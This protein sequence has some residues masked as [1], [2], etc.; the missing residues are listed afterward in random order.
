MIA[1]EVSVGDQVVRDL[2]EHL[3][4]GAHD[5][6]AIE[7]GP[8]GGDE[9][10]ILSPGANYGWPV[11]TYGLNYDGTIVSD[12]TEKEGMEQPVHYWV[13]SIA[14]SGLL[15]YSGSLIPEWTGNIFVGGLNGQQVARVTMNG[16]ESTGEET[17]YEGHGRIRDIRQGPD[18]AIYL[19][20]DGGADDA[21][22]VRI[23]PAASN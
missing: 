4:A 19:G 8:R 2:A 6:V 20:I 9:L 22:I 12:L 23:A 10:N 15:V 13:P 17:I 21:A 11:I 5:T 16:A 18:G 7:H 1:L 3:E 14:T